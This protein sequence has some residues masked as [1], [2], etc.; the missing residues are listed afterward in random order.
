MATR[1]KRRTETLKTDS[2]ASVWRPSENMNATGPLLLDTHAW[3][4]LLEG[5]R[6]KLSNDAL[7]LIN[8]VSTEGQLFVSDISF[9]E[10]ANKA[11]KGRLLLTIDPVLWLDRA[12]EAPGLRHIA[13]DRRTLV[14][15]TRLQ[16]ESPADPAD[17]MLIATAQLM[18]ATLVT[19]D[20][21]IIACARATK[22]F[23]VC[24]IR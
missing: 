7:T 15:S 4:W 20:V 3:V 1:K 11:A 16:T 24:D 19:A 8:R 22:S 23:T 17:R 9:W 18:L 6:D 10:V 12:G 13:L 5:R 14:Q 2:A 21:S